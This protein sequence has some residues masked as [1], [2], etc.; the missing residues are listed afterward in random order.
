MDADD[1]GAAGCE[2]RGFLKGAVVCKCGGHVGH[3]D[4]HEGGRLATAVHSHATATISRPGLHAP[5]AGGEQPPA[6]LVHR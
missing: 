3:G 2:G 6:H 5:C 4:V 1:P